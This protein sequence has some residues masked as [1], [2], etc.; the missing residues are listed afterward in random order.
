MLAILCLLLFLCLTVV[1]SVAC[2]SVLDA[3]FGLSRPGRNTASRRF[4]RSAQPLRDR[5]F[6]SLASHESALRLPHDSAV[7]K[8]GIEQD[9][10]V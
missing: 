4:D 6:A 2:L 1:F 9:C 3:L 10:L 8:L 7:S 5:R